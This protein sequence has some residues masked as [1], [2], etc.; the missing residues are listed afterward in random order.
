MT[1]LSLVS[2]SRLLTAT[3]CLLG[4]MTLA[5]IAYLS[6]PMMLYVARR[7]AEGYRHYQ[8]VAHLQQPRAD[9]SNEFF[10]DLDTLRSF[11]EAGGGMMGGMM[12]GMGTR[13]AAR[14]GKITDT[15]G[16]A[17]PNATYGIVVPAGNKP[18]MLKNLYASLSA[19]RDGVN[20]D[21]PVTVSYYGVRERISDE[22]QE[23]FMGRFSG[24]SFVDLSKIE[25]PAYQRR[26]D[27]DRMLYFG[28]KVK[29][30]ALYA[31]PYDHV[32]L[33]D[34]DSVPLV[35]P[36]QL[37][38]SKAYLEHG[39][40]FWP[41]RWCEPVRLFEDLGM[42]GDNGGR[43][44]VGGVGGGNDSGRNRSDSR[45]NLA[46]NK[47][48]ND[49][50]LK[51][52]YKTRQ[53]DSGQVLFDRRQYGDV[54]EYLLFLNAHDEFTYE[55]AYGDKDTY[56][57][58]FFLAGKRDAFYQVKTGLS[59]GLSP[60]GKPLGFLQGGITALDGPSLPFD[61]ATVVHGDRSIAFVH[62][63]SEAK[64]ERLGGSGGVVWV[65]WET[66]CE[67]NEKY[68]HFFRPLRWY[69]AGG[70]KTDAKRG[71]MGEAGWEHVGNLEHG[72]FGPGWGMGERGWDEF[73]EVWYDSMERSDVG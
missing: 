43:G 51:R 11:L 65:L 39:N 58:A 50:N 31:A 38:A 68:W 33:L 27:I 30:L 70:A 35:D 73:E 62:R 24:V 42:E 59:V 63:T 29:V 20:S 8:F 13:D 23:M 22:M 64:K 28:F 48:R 4:L 26:I 16:N 36:A 37:F 61:S 40:V 69:G 34:S 19:L 54:L 47:K 72:G 41:D 49:S 3:I 1:S 10:S 55:R 60:E 15:S 12:G 52:R 14:Q 46:K 5:A 56:E 9:I 6:L 17:T 21:L 25:Y 53:T 32:L 2:T 57:A 45:R 71:T 7:C 44:I 18:L 67:W 66:A